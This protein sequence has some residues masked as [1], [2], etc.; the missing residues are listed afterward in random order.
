M[1]RLST[2]SGRY[3]TLVVDVWGVLIDGLVAYDPALDA[4]RRWRRAG[5]R[6][7]LVSNAPRRAHVVAAQLAEFGV[8]PVLYDAIVTSG[9]SAWR[10][11]HARSGAL[12]RDLGRR[13]LHVGPAR[14]AHLLDG[15]DLAPV[16]PGSP[17]DFILTTAPWDDADTVDSYDPLLSAARAAGTPMICCNPDLDAP[18]GSGRVMC[19]GSIAARYEE[20]GGTV[21]YH[22]KPTAGIYQLALTALGGVDGRAPDRRDID[23][24]DRVLA[25][26]DTL[27]TDIRGANAFGLDSLLVADRPP[28]TT[29]TRAMDHPTFTAPALRW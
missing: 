9:E 20:L 21:A 18:R 6:V 26:G 14:D 22:G 27:A 16:S 8:D 4:L 10:A 13:C 12:Y 17:C 1:S 25:I 24:L 7:V 3:D 2:L 11:L 29:T 5:R 19:A 15:L 28:S 23:S